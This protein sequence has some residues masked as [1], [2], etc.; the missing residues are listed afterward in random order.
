MVRPDGW[1]RDDWADTL[2]EEEVA[3]AVV[4][5]A[6]QEGAPRNELYDSG[7]TRHISPYQSDFTSYT[8][9]SPPVFLNDAN[10]QRFPTIGTR[11]LAFR[12]PNEGTESELALRN[13]LHAP[14]VAYTLVSLGALDQE[15][16]HC[17]LGDGRIEIFSPEGERVGQIPRT[18]QCLYKVNRAPESAHATELIS[19]ME[20][21]RR[22][23]HIAVASAC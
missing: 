17:Y 6:E 3:C 2:F 7:A 23:G 8:P 16:Y 14:S 10:Q 4:T 21:H 13:A 18:Q 20:L 1:V 22:M 11:T 9:L 15:G 5:S 19:V 12:V